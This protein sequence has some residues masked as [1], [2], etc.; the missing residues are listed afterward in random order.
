MKTEFPKV[1]DEGTSS[2][3]HVRVAI[4]C[5]GILLFWDPHSSGVLFSLCEDGFLEVAIRHQD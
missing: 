1:L 2:F 3:N 4:M 5:W